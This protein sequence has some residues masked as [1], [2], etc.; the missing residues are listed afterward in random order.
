MDLR[1]GPKMTG[2]IPVVIPAKAGPKATPTGGPERS[3][4]VSVA[5]KS[6]MLGRTGL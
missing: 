5:H 4:R 6:K 1:W 3:E 2:F